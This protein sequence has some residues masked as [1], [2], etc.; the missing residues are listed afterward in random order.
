M[1]DIG[2]CTVLDRDFPF[3]FIIGAP[4]R[5]TVNNTKIGGLTSTGK[6]LLPHYNRRPQYLLLFENGHFVSD[7]IARSYE[8]LKIVK[9]IQ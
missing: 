3:N 1:N 6:S 9:R 7:F 2:F 8:D 4:A 5:H